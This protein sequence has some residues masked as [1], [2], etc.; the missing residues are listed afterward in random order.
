MNKKYL[1]LIGLLVIVGLFLAL[2]IQYNIDEGFDNQSRDLSLKVASEGP[3][4]VA[5][6]VNDIRTNDYYKN[7]NNDTVKWLEKYQNTHVILSSSDEFV[8]ISKGEISRIPI[9]NANDVIIN[10]EIECDLV[11][12]HSIGNGYRDI[13]LVKNVKYIGEE[14]K[15][16]EDIL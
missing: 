7:Y 16:I 11:E 15:S 13:L 6:V 8:L 14:V 12:N 5:G 3:F 4:P 9:Q 10:E 1:L 2:L